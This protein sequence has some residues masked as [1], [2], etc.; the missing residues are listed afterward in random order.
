MTSFPSIHG[1]A[2]CKA[3]EGTEG[4]SVPFLP[5][6]PSH[7]VNL[8]QVC[9]PISTG[10]CQHKQ[11]QRATGAA[12]PLMRRGTIRDQFGPENI[13]KWPKWRCDQSKE[14]TYRNGTC[15]APPKHYRTMVG[16]PLLSPALQPGWRTAVPTLRTRSHRDARCSFI[17]ESHLPQLC[18]LGI[19]TLKPGRN[20]TWSPP[21][22]KP[23]AMPR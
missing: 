9:L 2:L 1:H 5:S 11:W 4:H 17:K 22:G 12:I 18:P 8:I 16:S 14:K 20:G 3:S 19:K 7:C 15:M 6:L 13:W 21:Q 23:G 10:L